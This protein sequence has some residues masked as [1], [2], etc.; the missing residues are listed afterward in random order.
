MD[1]EEYRRRAEK[2]LSKPAK[3]GPDLDVRKFPP[4][5]R[6]RSFQEI[7]RQSSHMLASL[8]IDPSKADTSTYI[9][10]DEEPVELKTGVEGVR[11]YTLRGALKENLVDEY[12]WKAV[13][14]D[15]DKYTA[16]A[17]L[18]GN[19]QGYVII[20]EEG[21]KVSKPVQACLLMSTPRSIQAPHN[22]IIVN[23][24]AELHVVTGCLTMMEMPGLHAGISEFY[25][26]KGGKLTYTMIHQW[27]E[28][29]HV[30]PRTA[31]IVEE[32][33]QYISHYINLTPTASLQTDPKVYL[34]GEGAKAYLSSVIVSKG[35]SIMDVGGTVYMRAANTSAE[36]VSRV[37]TK[38]R[39]QVTARSLISAEASNS[40][41]H[42]ECDGLLL[43]KE[44]RIL[45]LPSLD[46]KIDE[47]QL[48]HEAAVG[49]LSEEQIYY[50][51]TKGFSEEEATNMLVRG[52]MEV[53]VEG[54]PEQLKRQIKAAID[55]A[56]AGL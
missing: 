24:G 50:L 52:F 53:K 19:H 17:E 3:Y 4:P 11:L 36:I 1:L 12:F 33:G 9:Q 45:T 38:D 15:A 37:V 46:A 31:V 48:S 51:M 29:T 18:F 20:A 30:R 14:V 35:S 32:G 21:A 55:L 13:Q 23:E 41:G 56:A 10:I 40:K 28:S 22:I 25:I 6:P 44:S 39:A 5:K 16:A 43:S 47:V 42:I 54:L 2:A 7:L 49:K 26:K 27:E 34:E 8:G